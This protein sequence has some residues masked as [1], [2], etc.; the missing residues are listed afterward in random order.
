MLEPRALLYDSPQPAV[1]LSRVAAALLVIASLGGL[2]LGGRGLYD[3][4]PYLL[5]QL[6]GQD[7]VSLGLALPLLLLSMRQ[8]RRASTRGLLLWIG[9]LFYLVYSYFFYVVGVRFNAL[10]PVYIGLVST[11]LFALLSLLAR[12]D[13]DAVRDRFALDYPVRPVAGYLIAMAMLFGI[14]WL[15]DVARSIITGEPLGEVP[16]LVYAVDLTLVLPAMALAGIWLWRGRPWGY[17]LA[18]LLLVKIAALGVTLLINTV[19]ALGWRQ[20]VSGLLT[21]V[22]AVLTLGAFACGVHFFRGIA[23]RDV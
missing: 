6:Y 22:F 15:G 13:G 16:R 12:I 20:E 11:S 2:L 1:L 3:P 8:A 17:T 9:V 21:A 10:F 23:A 19:I 7:A 14:L 4:D 18:G 5:P